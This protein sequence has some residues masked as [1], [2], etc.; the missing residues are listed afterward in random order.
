MIGST[1]GFNGAATR[2]SRI[3]AAAMLAHLQLILG[4]ENFSRASRWRSDS[5]SLLRSSLGGWTHLF[6]DEGFGSLDATALDAALGRTLDALAAASSLASSRAF[7]ALRV[8]STTC[9][10]FGDYRAATRSNCSTPPRALF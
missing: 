5:W 1:P 9:Y 3:A 7:V 6:C 2:A 8:R 4:N 10:G